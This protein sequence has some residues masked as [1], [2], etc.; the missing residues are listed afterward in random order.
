MD[1]VNRRTL[2]NAKRIS[3]D[4]QP[5][6]NKPIM[7]RMF[8]KLAKTWWA[9]QGIKVAAAVSTA[10][11]AALANVQVKVGEQTVDLLNAENEA[12]IALGVSALVMGGVEIALSWLAAKNAKATESQLEDGLQ[13]KTSDFR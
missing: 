4:V 12:A 7:Q 1:D 13:S 2:D 11:A 3:S 9:R 10:A 8:L 5:L 6:T